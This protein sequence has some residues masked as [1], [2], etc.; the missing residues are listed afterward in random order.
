MFIT[1]LTK[2]VAIPPKTPP[3]ALPASQWI[4]LHVVPKTHNTIFFL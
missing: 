1:H 4:A 2:K 3:F